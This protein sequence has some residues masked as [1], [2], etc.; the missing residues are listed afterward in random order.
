MRFQAASGFVVKKEKIPKCSG[1]GWK[2][3]VSER[4]DSDGAA[5]KEHVTVHELISRKD[6]K[7]TKDIKSQ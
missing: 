6:T 2:N 5:V 1:M 3:T 7:S 4:H